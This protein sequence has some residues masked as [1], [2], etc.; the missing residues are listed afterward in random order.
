MCGGSKSKANTYVCA[1]CV[2]KSLCLD[3][4]V[5]QNVV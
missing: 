4:S 5:Q 1:I 2:Y 3:G